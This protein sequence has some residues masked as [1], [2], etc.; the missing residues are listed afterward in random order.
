MDVARRRFFFV[1]SF[2]H[3]RAVY[4]L[5]W[6][7]RA[8]AAEIEAV[9]GEVVAKRIVELLLRAEADPIE[10]DQLL[11]RASK[12]A[13]TGLNVLKQALKQEQEAASD[14]DEN[15]SPMEVARALVEQHHMVNGLLALRHRS[16]AFYRWD[17]THYREM[18]GE[19]I[20]GQ[21]YHFMDALNL[22]PGRNRVASVREAVA[23]VTQV[24]N[25]M[26][27]PAWLSGRQD[28]PPREIIA[29]Q[30]G[31]LHLPTRQLLQHS[32][33]FFGWNALPFPYDVAAPLPA[34]WLK[35]L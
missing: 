20:R 13:G 26:R 10:T 25:G 2:A 8:I 32:P 18:A 27:A 12:K 35:F 30:N 14:E 6:D 29:V 34:R 28:P 16:D 24:P 4:D 21:I 5:R 22:K 19:E 31:L 15:F 7:G 1:H 11:R 3:G 33:M 17:T 9:P 23:A